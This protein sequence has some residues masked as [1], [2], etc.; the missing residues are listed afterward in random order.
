MNTL[1]RFAIH[2][3]RWRRRSGAALR[4]VLANARFDGA[5]PDPTQ[6]GAARLVA[7]VTTLGPRIVQAIARR[8]GPAYTL[9]LIRS[10]SDG[11]LR[12]FSVGAEEW[13][14]ALDRGPLHGRV[15]WGAL[16]PLQSANAAGGQGVYALV[17]GGKTLKIGM[18]SDFKARRDTYVQHARY[19]GVLSS[20][21][22]RFGKVSE[23]DARGRIKRVAGKPVAI[24]DRDRLRTVEHLIKRAMER[25]LKLSKD[26]RDQLP[27]SQVRAA[28]G[29]LRLRGVLPPEAIR[30]L[31]RQPAQRGKAGELLRSRNRV[32]V[33]PGQRY[34]IWRARVGDES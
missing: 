13:E 2:L 31:R 28:G 20:T 3:P 8:K 34:E 32:R 6:P 7:F 27:R 23:L 18:T 22:V 24:Q 25:N 5:W 10:R 16:Q 26:F 1:D 33:A 17:R 11:L 15:R 9:L 19:L 14:G 4:R 30:Q 29:D 21:K 12:E